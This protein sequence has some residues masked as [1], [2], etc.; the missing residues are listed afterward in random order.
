MQCLKNVK[1]YHF[2]LF[3]LLLFGCFY[4]ITASEFWPITIS[5]TWFTPQQFEFSMLQKPL[6][7]IFL[8]CFHLLPLTDI[9]HLLLV[10][11][12]FSIIGACGIWALTSFLLD[13]SE[14][15]KHH[16][17]KF[18]GF[19]MLALTLLSPT[20]LSHF[21]SIRSDQ[22]AT[23][24]F[25]F[26]LMFSYRKILIPSL[27]CLALIPLAGIKEVF[28]IPA[29]LLIIY[30]HFN[31]LLSRRFLLFSFYAMITIFVWLFAFNIPALYYFIESY[32][33][34][35]LSLAR[36]SSYFLKIESLSIL[37]AILS[38]LYIFKKSLKPL[39]PYV[40]ISVYFVLII[41]VL[42]QPFSFLIGSLLPFILVPLAL[43]L[44]LNRE[45]KILF[46]SSLI[47]IFLYTLTIR[48]SQNA[49]IYS[50]SFKQ[51]QYINRISEIISKNNLHY[52]D[53]VGILPRQDHYPCFAS[54]NDDVANTS[55]LDRIEH[56][57]LDSIIITS[58][59]MYVGEQVFKVTDKKY[60]Q[61]LPNF[62]VHRS[63]LNEDI[64]TH[65]N[66]GPELSPAFV[67]F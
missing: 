50:S 10:K 43:V 58:R 2:V 64:L 67:L 65:K 9:S 55:C 19:G 49:F 40:L 53:G 45:R 1:L 63:K 66:K 33:Q 18:L 60:V 25:S 32:E 59:L 13:I 41:I 22:L 16:K 30:F 51:L 36:L 37:L 7:T 62:W 17:D 57:S 31:H 48:F 26:F 28:F 27:V 14:V 8:A 11:L 3:T 20:I 15:P 23:T 35:H 24:F 61:I 44:L 38:G 29:G 4:R 6:L 39:Y 5:K 47:V 56:Q 52:L 54:P 42:P 12:V 46:F 21:F 34:T